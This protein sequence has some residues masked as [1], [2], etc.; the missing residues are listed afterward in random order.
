[1]VAVALS[2]SDDRAAV[3]DYLLSPIITTYIDVLYRKGDVEDYSW[4]MLLEPF[5]P[6][7][8]LM[9]AVC[10]TVV[11]LLYGVLELHQRHSGGTRKTKETPLWFIVGS[12]LKQGTVITGLFVEYVSML[13]FQFLLNLNCEATPKH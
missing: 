10:I 1:M 6:R 3:L 4:F 12:I 11:L 13:L 9:L 7:V 5:Q 8:L 2:M